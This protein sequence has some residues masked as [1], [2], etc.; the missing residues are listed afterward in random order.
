MATFSS[1]FVSHPLEL[2]L[3]DPLSL[4]RAL[5]ST[6]DVVSARIFRP[7]RFTVVPALRREDV[8]FARGFPEVEGA[9]EFVSAETPRESASFDTPLPQAG[10]PEGG[11]PTPRT[12]GTRPGMRGNR[13]RARSKPNVF[14]FY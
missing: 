7:K 9:L 1:S 14:K 10:S 6:T 2:C 13:E 8:T 12:C 11:I 5:G 3:L 4:F